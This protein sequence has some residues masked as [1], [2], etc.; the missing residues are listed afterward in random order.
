MHVKYHT[1]TRGG[2]RLIVSGWST[3]LR[4]PSFSDSRAKEPPGIRLDLHFPS[5]AGVGWLDVIA[6]IAG[7]WTVTEMIL[8]APKQAYAALDC[9]MWASFVHDLAGLEAL[10]QRDQCVNALLACDCTDEHAGHAVYL[11]MAHELNEIEDFPGSEWIH[12]Q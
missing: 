6:T 3:W 2:F 9:R 11:E 7:G 4:D 10:D 1:R 8:A 5:T 12:R